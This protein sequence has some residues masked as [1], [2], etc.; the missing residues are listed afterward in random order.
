MLPFVS[1][2][3]LGE[4]IALAAVTVK[5]PNPQTKLARPVHAPVM[6][7]ASAIDWCVSTVHAKIWCYVVEL[8]LSITCQAITVRQFW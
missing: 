2:L 7:S 4:V 8:C 6:D 3:N 1:I 5:A